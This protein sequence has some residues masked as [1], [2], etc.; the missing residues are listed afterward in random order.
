MSSE[1]RHYCDPCRRDTH[2]TLTQVGGRGAYCDGCGAPK[3]LVGGRAARLVRTGDLLEVE[4]AP[5]LVLEVE[6]LDG[7]DVV[8]VTLDTGDQVDYGREDDTRGI[9]GV[10]S[11]VVL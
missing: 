11:Q 10:L 4:E 3:V 5:A 8:R 2:T 1:H 9:P 7:G 6:E